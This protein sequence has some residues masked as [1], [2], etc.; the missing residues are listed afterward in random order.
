MT[1][2]TADVLRSLSATPFMEDISQPGEPIDAWTAADEV[3]RVFGRRPDLDSLLVRKG[4][5]IG[6]LMRDAF[7]RV[8]SGRLGYGS[9][10][11]GHRP[12]E[13]LTDWDPLVLPASL[14]VVE[15]T[16]VVLQRSD[17][18]RYDD[19]LV[20]HDAG[21]LSI[22]SV[23]RLLEAL[24]GQLAQQALTDP[25]TGLGNRDLFQ[26][27]LDA[28]TTHPGTRAAVLFLDLDDFKRVNDTLGHHAGD[29]LLSA[30]GRRM[31]AA[32][33]GQD[34]A[35]RI[36]GD[37]FAAVLRLPMCAGCQAGGQCLG[38]ELTEAR[39]I[40]DRLLRRFNDPFS[41][42]RHRLDVCASVGVAVAGDADCTSE[43]L[44]SV[45][46]HAM[47]RAKHDGAVHAELVRSST[48]RRVPA[49]RSGPHPPTVGQTLVT[50]DLR[51]HYQPIVDVTGTRLTG[52]EALLRW[53]HP[54]H[55]LVGPARLLGEITQHRL[56]HDL[57]SW[58]FNEACAQLVRWDATVE[59][60]AVPSV[61]V[62]ASL[63]GLAPGQLQDAVTAALETSGLEP[64]RLRLEI[65]ETATQDQLAPVAGDLRAIRQLGVHLIVDDVGTGAATLRHLSELLHD[66][67]K[68]DRSFVAGMLTNER[69]H[70]IVQMLV[71]LSRV[72]GVSIVA[73]GVE[74][75][76]QCEALRGLGCHEQ[77]GFLLSR[78][79]G[80]DVIAMLVRQPPPGVRA[81]SGGDPARREATSP[82]LPART[83][84]RADRA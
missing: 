61:S 59:P 78:P 63:P 76:E 18:R 74:T 16:S 17:H 81:R 32:L 23:A 11:H 84:G 41:V 27:E 36:G 29:L 67:L 50:G 64:A 57:N 45:A 49:P 2:L 71:E 60:H 83:P 7:E 62:N 42:D 82:P 66:G 47:Y 56:A 48:P 14:S 1:A 65:P 6:L 43:A 51:L 34:V 10:L 21:H 58:V 3:R 77:Q 54:I 24:T 12:V 75:E 73:E 68:I 4:D 53:Q 8:M 30:V 13:R 46:D 40:A 9:A 44:L 39:T 22:A 80:A 15:A 26:R 70:A 25:L 37:E 55:G 72:V 33:R 38:T 79:V 31:S 19:V 35:V 28:A 69:D 5:R 20:R 52:V